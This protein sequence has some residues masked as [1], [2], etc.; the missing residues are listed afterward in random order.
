MEARGTLGSAS[1]E[2]EIAGLLNT[3]G[4]VTLGPNF[5]INQAEASRAP[6]SIRAAALSRAAGQRGNVS[7]RSD[8]ADR[9]VQTI[10]HKQI[11]PCVHSYASRMIKPRRCT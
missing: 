10:H 4:V 8:L 9:Q 11:A 5:P 1:A 2:S 3:Q 7:G 6:S